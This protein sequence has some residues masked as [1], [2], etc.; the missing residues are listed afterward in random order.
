MDIKPFEK[1]HLPEAA[2]IFLRAYE[3]W[4]ETE[5]RAYLEKFLGF[6]PSSC[7]VAIVDGKVAGAVLGYWY[8]RKKEVILF[9]Q[10]LFVDPEKRKHGVGRRLVEALRG[11]FVENP[12]INVTPLVKAD[13]SVLSFYNSLGFEHDLMVSYYDG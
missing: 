12:K 8:P 3:G 9:I 1:H 11:S 10:E 4:S 5:A 6:D 13:G 2:A 7:R